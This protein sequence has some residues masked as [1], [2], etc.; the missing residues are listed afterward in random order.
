MEPNSGIGIDPALARE[1]ILIGLVATVGALPIAV[2][3]VV[4]SIHIALSVYRDGGAAGRALDHERGKTEFTGSH[5]VAQ[6]ISARRRLFNEI[7]GPEQVRHI[8]EYS[9]RWVQSRYISYG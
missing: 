8:Q 3:T 6:G 2:V 4:I 5:V 9:C 7:G 1:L